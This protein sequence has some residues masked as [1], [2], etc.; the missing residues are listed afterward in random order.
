MTPSLLTQPDAW[1]PLAI[2]DAPMPATSGLV[3]ILSE[4]DIVTARQQGRTL[5]NRLGFSLTEATL[6][7]TVIS[8]LARNILLYAGSGT[9]VLQTIDDRTPCGILIVA[10][11]HGP[12]IA[13][14][15]QA[16]AG[17]Y[18]TSGGLGLGLCGVRGLVDDFDIV[19]EMGAGT[20]VTLRKWIH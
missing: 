20:T 13:D 10:S 16:L 5:A 4:A 12:G 1:A 18:S 14:L 2:V 8:E 6:V 3:A 15:R 19:S 9:I 7:A 17:G 11:D